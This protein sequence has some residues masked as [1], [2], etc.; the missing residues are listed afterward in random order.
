MDDFNQNTVK[1][2]HKKSL[3]SKFC[4]IFV[5]N[6]AQVWGNFPAPPF[7]KSPPPGNMTSMTNLRIAFTAILGIGALAAAQP[8]HATTAKAAVDVVVKQFGKAYAERIISVSGQKGEP[9]P[10]A[11]HVFAY[12]LQQQGLVSHFVVQNGKL[13]GAGLL[14]AARS[15]PLAG[16]RL[17]WTRIKLDSP[18]IFRQANNAAINAKV[19]FDSIDYH[20]TTDRRN[21]IPVFEVWL[22]NAQG[23]IV[24][25]LGISATDGRIVSSNFPATPQPANRAQAG[26]DGGTWQ[27]VRREMNESFRGIGDAFRKFGRDVQDRFQQ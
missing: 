2:L 21:N 3:K 9:E 25:T 17:P 20:L 15:H 24:G 5:V 26:G 11:W 22:K 13:A 7:D 14:D 18:Q 8:A 6:A 19:G 16:P 27:A 12:D 23:R 4:N 10:A 1:R